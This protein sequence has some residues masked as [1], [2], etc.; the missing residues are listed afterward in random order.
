MGAYWRKFFILSWKNL[1]LKKRHWIMTILEIVIPTLLFIGIVAIRNFGGAG[2]NPSQK[3]D[4]PYDKTIF[5]ESICES[6]VSTL[7]NESIANITLYYYPSN[8]L[9]DKIVG[10]IQDSMRNVFYPFCEQAFK[11]NF[12]T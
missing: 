10:T 12:S 6:L 1:L 11:A 3:P 8:N 2:Y 5:P 7:S 4:T 9:T